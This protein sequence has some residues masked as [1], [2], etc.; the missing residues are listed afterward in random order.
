MPKALAPILH[1]TLRDH[2]RVPIAVVDGKYEIYVQDNYVRIF[3]EDDLPDIIK[4]RLSMIRAHSTVP[5]YP[6]PIL[7]AKAYEHP[8][9]SNMLEIGWI[10]C[11]GLYVVVIPTKDLTYI[12][13]TEYRSGAR[14]HAGFVIANDIP[15]WRY[16]EQIVEHKFFLSTVGKFFSG[17]TRE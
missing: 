2:H 4:A 7:V 14:V 12:R 3:D 10:V 9:D 1:Q 11:E 8:L 16:L 17:H 15:T 6:D 13:K 5:P